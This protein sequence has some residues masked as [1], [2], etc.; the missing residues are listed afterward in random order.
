[1][2]LQE[3]VWAFIRNEF[4]TGRLWVRRQEIAEALNRHPSTISEAL[5]RLSK[6]GLI[7]QRRKG[8]PWWTGPRL[9][10]S[11]TS[12]PPGDSAPRGGGESGNGSGGV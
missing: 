9:V 4:E 12:T 8:G 5:Y 6:I 10:P 2:T 11:S 1:M 3:R 7:Q